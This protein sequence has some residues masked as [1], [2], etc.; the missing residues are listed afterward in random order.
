MAV[1]EYRRTGRVWELHHTYVPDSMRGQGVAAEL[2]R[3]TLNHIREQGGVV[4][5]SC[6]YI[7]SFIGRN[8]DYASL[9]ET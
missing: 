8:S 3:V 6:S 9:L 5:P 7:K 2:A 1:C 4:R